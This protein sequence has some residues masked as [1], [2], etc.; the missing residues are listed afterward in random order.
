MKKKLTKIQKRTL[1]NKKF[2]EELEK[3]LLEW[4]YGSYCGISTTWP[5][6]L[7]HRLSKDEFNKIIEIIKEELWI[8]VPHDN[9]FGIKG[10]YVYDLE[11]NLV[12]AFG[13]ENVP[14][15]KRETGKGKLKK[16][17]EKEV[18]SKRNLYLCQELGIGIKKN[19][20]DYD[21]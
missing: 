6:F 2:F 21:Y 12:L 15:N 17:F 8:L 11:R 9:G 14:I 19:F 20:S 3:Q 1:E 5:D 10:Y 13:K 16:I 18:Q 7:E 4:R